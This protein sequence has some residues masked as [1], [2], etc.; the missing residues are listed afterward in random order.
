V[1]VALG[2]DAHSI[3]GLQ[4][5]KYGIGQAR[6]GW[7]EPKDILNTRPLQELIKLLGRR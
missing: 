7:L 6:R 5:M 1:K 4:F 2:T 3:D